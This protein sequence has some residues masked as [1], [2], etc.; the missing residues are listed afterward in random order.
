M[1]DSTD[2]E[3]LFIV[4][5]RIIVANTKMHLSDFS[6]LP[7]KHNL[8]YPILKKKKK[9]ITV[10]FFSDSA[11]SFVNPIENNFNNS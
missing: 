4:R 5:F 6:G 3:N 1:F 7:S 11:E 2:M 10:Y 8:L 9:S